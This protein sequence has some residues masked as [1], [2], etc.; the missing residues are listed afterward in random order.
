MAPLMGEGRAQECAATIGALPDPRAS[1]FYRT[2]LVAGVVGEPIS[3]SGLNI[4][5]HVRR[6]WVPFFLMG[7]RRPGWRGHHVRTVIMTGFGGVGLL[8]RRSIELN[9]GLPRWR[10]HANV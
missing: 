9:A 6:F 2:S 5:I 8:H 10:T 4:H 3:V 7:E 1:V